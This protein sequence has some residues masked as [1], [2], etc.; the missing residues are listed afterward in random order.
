M[1]YAV[2]DTNVVVSALITKNPNAATVKVLEAV[3]EGDVVPV[4]N[5]A[6]LEEY[7]EVLRRKKFHL[8]E[9]IIESIINYFKA[10]GLEEE[11]V[12]TDIDLPDEDDRVFYEVSLSIDD[13]L[14][15]TGNLKHYP[16]SSRIISPSDFVNIL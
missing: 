11:A 7:D 12:R 16:H 4:Y 10:F 9:S 14:L 8:D 2:I 6:I 15:V 3:L 1:I 13:A 5:S